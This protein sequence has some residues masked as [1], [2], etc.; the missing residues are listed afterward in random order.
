MLVYADGILLAMRNIDWGA[1]NIADAIG[2]K[3]GLNHLQAMRELQSKGFVMLDKA[4][5]T[6]EQ[7]VFSQAIEGALNQFTAELRL[8]MLELQSEM[9]LQWTKGQLLGGA[10]QLK[11]FGAFL[12]QSF[13]IPFNRFKQF[14]HHPA[15]T[16]ETNPHLEMVTGAAVGLAIEALRRPRNPATNFM[17]GPFAQQSQFFES[18]WEKWGYTAQLAGIAFVI[19][20]TYGVIREN[21]ASSLADESD[22]V[23]RSQAEQIAGIKSRQASPSRIN[24]FI[25]NQE[26]LEKSR[27]SAE[28]VVRMNSAM[29]VLNRISAVL[30]AKQKA[31]LEIKRVSITNDQAEVQGYADNENQHTLIRQALS[32]AASDGKVEQAQ[33]MIKP[34]AGKVGFAYKF[35]VD[36]YTGG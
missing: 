9:N 35:R 3:Y 24:K 13:E 6:K 21:F 8:V 28:R 32:Q 30:P 25:N 26:K 1:K 16:A 12:T 17:K 15:V 33:L 18:L 27:K 4:Q 7:I 11:N 36:R 2:S 22:R 23:M 10:S 29:D 34:P 19:M 5:G 20:L 14:E 31:T